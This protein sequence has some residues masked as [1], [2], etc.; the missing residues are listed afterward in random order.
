MISRECLVGYSQLILDVLDVY[1]GDTS[2]LV[3]DFVSTD[4][5]YKT[6]RAIFDEHLPEPEFL[7]RMKSIGMPDEVVW[8]DDDIDE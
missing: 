3:A 8:E 5:I 2:V 6:A 4:E 1:S 7:K